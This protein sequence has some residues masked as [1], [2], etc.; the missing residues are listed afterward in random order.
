MA[1]PKDKIEEIRE[2]A[3]I[4]QVVSEYVPL[5]KRGA[6]HLGLCPFHSE[7][8]PSFT[9]SEEK[10]IFYCFGCNATGNVIT[11]LMKK[12]G[13]AFPDAVRSLAARYGI[14]IS[15]SV[16]PGAPDKRE[17]V[18]SA[19]K[20][21]SEYFL[22]ELRTSEGARAREYLKGRGLT[23]ELAKSFM[24]GFAP[25]RW[26]GLTGHLKRK[27]VDTD[28]ALSA[29]LIVKREKSTGHYDRFRGRV[30]FP[31][32]DT[33]G[34]IIG[35][36]GRTMD[37][38]VQPK[39][40]NSPE[41][42]VFRKGETLFGLSQAREAIQKEGSV[43]V[44]EGYFDLVAL[45]KHGFNNSVATMGTALTAEHVRLLKGYTASIY[46]L[47]DA[48]EAGKKAAIRGLDLFLNEDVACRAVLLDKGKD[49]DE[50]LKLAGPEALREAVKEAPTLME[51]YLRNLREKIDTASPEGKKRYFRESLAY[52]SRIKD[53]AELGHYASIV[54]STLGIGVE[55]VYGSLKGQ[56][57]GGGA[58]RM[59][60]V[61]AS[62]TPRPELIILR[63][64]LKHPA[65]YSPE[66]D[67]AIGRFTDPGLKEAGRIISGLCREGKS[68]SGGGLLD[69]VGEEAVKARLAELLLRE[70]DGFVEEPEKMLKD[71]LKAV[72]NRG[73]V[74]PST[75]E[76]AEWSIR[77]LEETGKSELARDMKKK[78]EIGPHGKRSR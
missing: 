65:F 1:I 74:K 6:N 56:T 77:L 45:V 31:I 3:S 28:A 24:I 4:V 51:F 58:V 55:A 48:D 47:F 37:D 23:G 76:F 19:L 52:L 36:G 38:K 8:T 7:K 20:A 12:E 41:S 18:Y 67:Q 61:P 42:P 21:A 78:L 32:T 63:V 16:R 11:F 35:F 5:T 64:L 22:A 46:C 2:R 57:E 26:D 71:S 72:L 43:I 39:Y 73:G 29:G 75:M 14:T 69:N 50:F 27:G 33:R 59:K 62:A 68:L 66:V 13:L 15:E 10:K 54:A 9:V 40:L 30:V 49:P 34:R 25:D 44:V 53:V 17:A 60:G 70:D